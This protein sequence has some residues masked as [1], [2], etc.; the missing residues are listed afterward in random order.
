MQLHVV[1]SGERKF[2]LY[3]LQRTYQLNVVC[4]LL[5]RGHILGLLIQIVFNAPTVEVNYS[6]IMHY[7]NHQKDES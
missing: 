3:K 2:L 4:I 7:L 5:N 6:F 1:T